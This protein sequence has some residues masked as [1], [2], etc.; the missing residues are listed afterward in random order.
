MSSAFCREGETPRHFA[1]SAEADAYAAL[2]RSYQPE[3]DFEVSGNRIARKT[4]SGRFD[5]WVS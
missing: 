3:F 4:K 1:T 2:L 5:G